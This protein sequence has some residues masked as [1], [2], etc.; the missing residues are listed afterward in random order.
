[1]KV[2]LRA[3]CTSFL[4]LP[5]GLLAQQS[6]VVTDNNGVGTGTT[7]W[8][9]ENTYILSGPVYV[10]PGDVLTIEPGTVIKGRYSPVA[11][12]NA[13]LIV[14][15]GAKII[16][17]GRENLPIIFTSEG[18]DLDF[19]GPSSCARANIT[20]LSDVEFESTNGWGPVERDQANGT[21]LPND[22]PRIQMGGRVYIKGLGVHASDPDP[23]NPISNTDTDIS[24]IIFDLDGEYDIFRSD[25]GA[26]D[27]KEFD[28]FGNPTA[29]SIEFVVL[30]DGA[31]KFTSGLIQAGDPVQ[32]VEVDVSG[33]DQLEL[34]ILNGGS[35]NETIDGNRKRT[36]HGNW[37]NARLLTCTND[38]AI[39]FENIDPA[40]LENGLWGGLVLLG[41]APSNAPLASRKI[42]GLPTDDRNTYGGNAEEDN[43]GILRYVSIRHGGGFLNMGDNIK[44]NGL[45]L[46]GVGSSTTVEYV[47][48]F[49]SF[50]D[51][52]ELCG[53]TVN[54]RYLSMAFSGDDSYDIDQ[55]YQGW[56][57]FWFSIQNPGSD[58]GIS[59]DGG[60]RNLV[61]NPITQPKIVNATLIGG[62]ADS[63]NRFGMIFSDGAGGRYGN[64]II[65]DFN[66][67]VR[68]EYTGGNNDSYT[69]YNNE[70]LVL[71]GNLFWNIGFI[72]AECNELIL[73]S[74][75]A[76]EEISQELKG[77]F[78]SANNV[79][80]NPVFE[81]FNGSSYAPEKR[82]LY[83]IPAVGGFAYRDIEPLPTDGAG[84]NFLERVPYKG[85][86]GSEMWLERW[87]ALDAYGFLGQNGGNENPNTLKADLV[88]ENL[89]VLLDILEPGQEITLSFDIKNDGEFN[90]EATNVEVFLESSSAILGSQEVR[91]LK[92]GESITNIS[93]VFN[94]P[95]DADAS[96]AFLLKLDTAGLVEEENEGNNEVRFPFII[97]QP[98]LP[99]LEISNLSA[100]P[101]P[102]TLGSTVTV[103][104]DVTN[105][106]EINSG[107]VAIQTSLDETVLNTTPPNISSIEAGA[108]RSF[109]RNVTIPTNI[110]PGEFSLSVL[111][112]PDNA[113]EE[114]DE[115]NN[116]A[117][118]KL[119]I[120]ANLPDLV[121]RDLSPEV[122]SV[123]AG[124]LFFLTF[125]AE[126]AGSAESGPIDVL[127]RLSTGEI[128]ATN[129]LSSLSGGGNSL[130]QLQVAIPAS[131]T[132]TEVTLE[133]I[134]DPENKIIEENED[135]NGQSVQLTVIPT[136]RM[137]PDLTLE[138]TQP[139]EDTITVT[140]GQA[141]NVSIR[142]GN[143][144]D[145][146]APENQIRFTFNDRTVDTLIQAELP[147]LSVRLLEN[148]S[149]FVPSATP[150]GF[151]A[152]VAK[153]DAKEEI[154]E[155]SESNNADTL[156]VVVKE[157]NGGEDLSI[158]LTDFPSFHTMREE[159]SSTPNITVSHPERVSRVVFAHKHI[160]AP[161]V[162][163]SF[164][165]TEL[166]ITE[167]GV[168]SA[169]FADSEVGPIGIT[170]FFRVFG[171]NGEEV[172]SELGHTH[173]RYNGDGL[174][175]PSIK[176]GNQVE[177]YQ[178]LAIPLNLDNKT[179]Q[180]VFLDD[181]GSDEEQTRWRL[182]QYNGSRTL[183]LTAAT[184]V[185]P[186]RSY[187]LL[188]VNSATID[189]GPG[190]TVQATEIDPAAFTLTTQH[191]Q[192][193]NPYNFPI[194]WED[195]LTANDNPEGLTFT[196]YNNGYVED[197]RLEAFEGG[198]IQSNTTPLPLAIPVFKNPDVNRLA[199]PQP[200]PINAQEW[201]L[202]FFLESG[203]LVHKVGGIGMHP[204]ASQ[205]FDLRDVEGFPRFETFLDFY[206]PE[207][208][209]PYERMAK[210]FVSPQE[211]YSWDMVINSNTG[212]PI[213]LSWENEGFG[214]NDR[215]LWLEDLDRG[216]V[217]DMR[218]E[219]MLRLPL[220]AEEGHFSIHYGD[221]AFVKTQVNK[222][223]PW[224]GVPFPN[225]MEDR[226]NFRVIH[227]ENTPQIQV[228]AK[229]YNAIGA[230]VA[231]QNWEEGNRYLFK[232]DLAKAKLAKG[233]Y[234]YRIQVLSDGSLFSKEGR[235]LKND[236]N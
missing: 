52:I 188:T 14:S 64:S 216:I 178:I 172:Q 13:M 89:P 206:F 88:F 170:Y 157:G 45:T 30:V 10:N 126:N 229:L 32:F 97:N 132:D 41:N 166:P 228:S 163:S 134:L 78:E 223:E 102:T 9:A 159:A 111:L 69:R 235:L 154:V 84:A 105:N 104:F 74:P 110:S 168:Y 33:A 118:V 77:Y 85:A 131:I 190:T 117:S 207:E 57:Q 211:Q 205:G 128:I 202:P 96:D 171:T 124:E 204:A 68:M 22:G 209:H 181:I 182:M 15:P 140:A 95:A 122:N 231:S 139:L 149:I 116:E 173:L 147:V 161:L 197:T 192:V 92:K 94:L 198:F 72:G 200:N 123:Q 53:G 18:D 146:L 141:F 27:D 144:G 236:G 70:D 4:L 66:S 215:Q 8:E 199:A 217:Y 184:N 81:T 119:E 186:G 49:S 98:E 35:V 60:D 62:G 112:D 142:V 162:E 130:V 195:I 176:T 76:P 194:L 153:V 67:G 73:P 169:S 233:I 43:S 11:G 121:I 79:Y 193:G 37:G 82:A 201:Y 19:I 55:G 220:G 39:L 7:T 226:V 115:D 107:A 106:G 47:D 50:D 191:T 54:A 155:K 152:F 91:A 46:A 44:A 51:G 219:N 151:Y 158:T 222:L 133:V 135:N 21:I 61:V 23:P 101:N 232:W 150:A 187:W 196:T 125:T 90:S 100:N 208:N 114:G 6:I 80:N 213:L 5:L 230:E 65:A 113:I 31:I 38:G 86:F 129:T 143:I 63:D 75:S 177:N 3:V 99:D 179:V 165:V 221:L 148:N 203:D 210:N 138:M 1:M 71:R 189:T 93:L 185:L 164:T 40:P 25:V 234:I 183:D 48:V 137:F 34:Q 136:E 16:A 87:S 2:F 120:P 108:T 224:I 218:A 127:V 42:A 12:D 17:E 20:Y 83:P 36:D 180:D 167:D 26:Q 174:T 59:H 160:S 109:S 175:L 56:G 24:R 212:N 29:L 214:E 227:P 103:N 225:P 156:I 58:V 28:L 145:S